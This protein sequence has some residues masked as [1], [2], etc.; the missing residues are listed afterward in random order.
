V[1]TAPAV[2]VSASVSVPVYA[3]AS[4]IE[5]VIDVRPEGLQAHAH[6]QGKEGDEQ[7]VLD[8]ILCVLFTDEPDNGGDEHRVRATRSGKVIA[9][10]CRSPST[11]RS[12]RRASATLRTGAQSC[13]TVTGNLPKRGG[14]V[15][16]CSGFDGD[17]WTRSTGE[18]YTADGLRSMLRRAL[19][20]AGIDGRGV[21]FHT[22]RHSFATR[23]VAASVDI[24]T[25]STILGHSTSRAVHSNVTRTSG[26]R[27]NTRR[28]P[29]I[30]VEQK[31]WRHTDEKTEEKKLVDGRRL[32]LPTSALRT[33]RSPN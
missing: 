21:S 18:P 15:L 13:A 32:E 16:P 2:R 33:R 3:A 30:L 23:L 9:R 12:N 6:R 22:L 27:A 19:D 25:V 17:E 4:T 28:S 8:Q 26:R 1:R 20:R 14:D 11:M 31:V 5:R 10:R 24:K 29:H 7:C